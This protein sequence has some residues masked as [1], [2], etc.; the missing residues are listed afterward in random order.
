M[1]RLT[2]LFVPSMPTRDRVGSGIVPLS[3]IAAGAASSR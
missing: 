2:R 3:R 1:K